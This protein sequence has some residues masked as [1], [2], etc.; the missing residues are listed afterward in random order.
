[1]DPDVF[2]SHSA[3]DVDAARQL[4]GHL[5]AGGYR[6]WMAPD[7]IAGPRSW[8][9]Q[10][11]GAIDA[12][13]A[14]VVLVSAN[15]NES[16]HVSREVDLAVERGTPLLPVRVEDVSPAGALEYLLRLAQWVDAFPG[17]M[18]D[19]AAAV[20]RSLDALVEQP[21]AGSGPADD[22]TPQ[23]PAP[24][25]PQPERRG[26]QRPPMPL[27]LAGTVILLIAAAGF[28]AV[29]NG[30]SDT[31][32]SGDQLTAP[33]VSGLDRAAAVAEFQS[34][35][36]LDGDINWLFDC[37]GFA[38]SQ[39]GVTVGQSPAAGVQV[40]VGTR[41]DILLQANDC[42]AVPD[43]VDS[44]LQNGTAAVVGASLRAVPLPDCQAT[45]AIG[46]ISA[47]S[48]T[49]GSEAVVDSEVVLTYRPDDC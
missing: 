8:A 15:S 37:S 12:S 10:I 3:R 26:S 4:R 6:C 45:G 2:I 17:P 18:T 11:V 19:H 36:F 39:V 35:G 27:W 29:R 43:V 1:M 21:A 33:D 48:I 7:D 16:D 41:V 46:V 42:T 47:Q 22:P 14:I 44:S 25:P 24:A 5:E 28:L 31:S 13:R 38:G 32:Q 30:N 49:G 23:A 9:E 34:A 20:Q 40:P